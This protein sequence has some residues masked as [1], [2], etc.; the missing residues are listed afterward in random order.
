MVSGREV[1]TY[2]LLHELTKTH[3]RRH[4]CN[5]ELESAAE[6]P[7]TRDLTTKLAER[8]ASASRES[9]RRADYLADGYT[10]PSAVAAS[11]RN[12][13]LA[14]SPTLSDARDVMLKPRFAVTRDG[15]TSMIR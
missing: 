2:I 12:L 15:V 7:S 9:T 14:L 6:V 4:D 1:E 11:Y 5:R 8:L 13:L 3:F 10:I